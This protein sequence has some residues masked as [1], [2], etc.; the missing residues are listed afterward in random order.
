[1]VKDSSSVA[2]T[3]SSKGIDRRVGPSAAGDHAGDAELLLCLR[4]R[5]DSDARS[6]RPTRIPDAGGSQRH[7]FAHIR[8]GRDEP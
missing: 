6:G 5:L 3:T 1:M 8:G 2:P 4:N 7:R